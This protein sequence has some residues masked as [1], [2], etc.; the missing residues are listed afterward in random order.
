MKTIRIT[1]GLGN[2]MFQ[3]AFL[4]NYKLKGETV[5][6]DLFPCV[7]IK[8][9]NGYELERIFKIKEETLNLSERLKI[10]GPFLFIGESEATFLKII[11]KI[12]ELLFNKKDFI[13]TK[14]IL[15]E[16]GVSKDF[17]Y[18][19]D[20]SEVEG[21]KYF[22][23]FFQS[24]KYFQKYDNVVRKT[25]SFP[26]IGE[27]DTKNFEVLKKIK[28][29]ESISMHIRR[30]DYLKF[31]DLNICNKDY[32]KRAFKLFESIILKRA[33]AVKKNIKIFVFSND[34]KW[35]KENLDFIND[36]NVVF[37]AWN[38][39]K[40]SYKDMQLMSECQ[41]NIIPNS[42]FSWWGG[43]LNKNPDKIVVAPK[44]WANGIMTTNDLCPKNWNL[45]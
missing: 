4:L 21:F 35:C 33:N 3:Y 38:K 31:P 24:Y 20:Y 17:F 8:N 26:N 14:R 44:Y 39:G 2:Q 32:Y 22:V 40:N 23:G 30:G 5:K 36:Y 28:D 25:F 9:H 19:K 12:I 45:V 34:I 13:M 18:K 11:N 27:S 43:Y 1:P 41:H 37:V 16:Y 42:T 6:L 29:S 7:H 10:T 15:K